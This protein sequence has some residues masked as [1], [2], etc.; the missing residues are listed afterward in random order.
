[1]NR[2]VLP[3]LLLVF[4]FS[5]SIS[6]VHSQENKSKSQNKNRAKKQKRKKPDKKPTIK[7]LLIAGGCC[8]DYPNQTQILTEGISQ[9]ASVEWEI[10]RGFSGRERMLKI[11]QTEDWAEG[12]DV[13]VH[14]ECYGGVTDV[15]FVERIVRGHTKHKV[16]MVAVHCSMHSY[17]N[18]KT[19]AW[20]QL[21]GVTS[22]RHEKQVQ[23]GLEVVNRASKNPIMKN[24][25]VSWSTPKGELYVIEKSWPNMRVLAT[26][27]G[28]QGK[29][30]QPCIWTNE[31]E[32]CRVFG[33]TLGHH[34]ETMLCD[35][36]LDT[37]ARGLLWA[38]QKLNEDGAP[39]KDYVGTGERKIWLPSMV[40][41]LAPAGP[42]PTPA[43]R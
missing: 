14:N 9:R 22:K 30:D 13:V 32:G 8:H 17:R 10:V 23:E 3:A 43:K 31:F 18:A 35:E 37:V 11:Y 26:A 7:A 38:C 29:K 20:R 33:T 2:L 15:E 16:P 19:D 28:V 4:F 5:L 41:E 12:Y 36:Y 24:F 25:G 27:Y 21:L 40:R 6:Q 39:V 1:M 34:N 42:S